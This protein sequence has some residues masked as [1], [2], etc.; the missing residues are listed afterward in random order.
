MN[1]KI[2]FRAMVIAIAL[3]TTTS[4][5]ASSSN[6]THNFSHGANA[7][8]DPNMETFIIEASTHRDSG[9]AALRD[10]IIEIE[11]SEGPFSP[12]LYGY[13]AELGR[14]H[15][16]SA[17]HDLAID[18][19][20]R[21]QT[22]THWADGV[23]SP[24]QLEAIRLQSR[25]LIAKGKLIEADKLER[26]HFRVSEKSFD[27]EALLPS[28]WRLSQWQW[29]TFQYNKA[30]ENYD[31]ALTMI[32]TQQ[33]SSAYAVQAMEAKALTE[34]LA[35]RCCASDSLENALA[36][37]LNSDF[38][39]QVANET[40]LLNLADIKLLYGAK[41]AAAFY[42]EVEN[43]PAAL[44]GPKSKNVYLS[45]LDSVDSPTHSLHMEVWYPEKTATFTFSDDPEPEPTP[46]TIG[47]PV[48]LCS[49]KIENEGF[50]DVSLDVG[51]N[52]TAQNLTITGDVPQVTKK[53]LRAVL[54]KSRYRPEIRNGE[55]VEQTLAFRQYFDRSKPTRSDLVS[56]WR[57]LLAEHACQIMAMR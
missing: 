24:M 50:V 22:L 28:L 42:T 9:R 49:H 2:L 45:A 55:A 47:E 43:A 32:E 35:K 33:L 11:E 46:V 16:A 5:K 4:T 39:D 19:F 6:L 17:E 40:A 13:L 37:R 3:A 52:G 44:L 20:Q 21:M 54:L 51:V 14:I 26:F 31:R 29:M 1:S 18:A 36:G 10:R 25:T 7:F 41:D 23:N 48:R 57:D 38:S 15:S 53:Y 27:G 12:R 56:G 8:H 34:H 30:L